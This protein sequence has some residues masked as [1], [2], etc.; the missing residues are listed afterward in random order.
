LRLID[1]IAERAGRSGQ[2]LLYITRS[3][4]GMVWGIVT[5]FVIPGM[6]YYNLSPF[7]AIKKSVAVLK[8]TWEESLIRYYGSGLAQFLFIVVGIIFNTALF[9]Y[10]QLHFQSYYLIK[11]GV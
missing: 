1:E 4:L 2:I 10:F 11:I 9:V 7:D 3:I 6:V 5:I 8:K